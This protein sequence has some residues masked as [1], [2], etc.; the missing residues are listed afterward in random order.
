MKVLQIN[1]TYNIGSTGRIVAGIEKILIGSGNESYCAFGYGNRVDTHHYK[2][3]NKVDSYIHNILSRLSDSQG[4]HS[5]YKTRKLIRYIEDVRPDIVHLHNL[6][7]NYINYQILFQ[8]LINSNV[9]VVWTLHDCWPFTGHCVYFD[10]AGCAKW[11][12]DCVKCPQLK[13]YPHSFGFDG[14]NSNLKIKRDIYNKLG[15][16]L[17]LV[18]V[19][20][21]L[22]S[23]LHNSILADKKI[24]TIHNGINI[25]SFHQIP[26]PLECDY[27]LGVAAGWTKRKGIEDI[28]KLRHKLSK[29]IKIVLIGLSKKQIQELPDGII[30]LMKTDSVKEL[31]AYYSGALALFNPTY[32]D[33][34]PTVNLESIA[35][36]TPVITYQTGG[37]PESIE[38]NI[39]CGFVVKQGDIDKTVEHINYIFE[40]KEQYKTK[41]IS[42][43]T[44]AFLNEDNC[45]KEYLKLYNSL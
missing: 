3:I 21:W 5:S 39:N 35:C 31:A 30:G 13:A 33:N 42:E 41:L 40:H 25:D 11:K 6:H 22:N 15:T 36:G 43:K 2:I 38:A 7:G 18:P 10:M 1:T 28:F 14:S 27:V 4:L 24:I 20:D 9:K 34:Y 32:E 17:T 8:Y 12:T 19:S 26:S 44:R 45:F 37:S 29:S 23:L 16:R